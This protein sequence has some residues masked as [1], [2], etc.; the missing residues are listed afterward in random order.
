MHR[1]HQLDCIA[2]TT[3]VQD[4][5]FILSTSM[6]LS[7]SI[8][9]FK[10]H[11][12]LLGCFL[13]SNFH[14]CQIS[15]PSLNPINPLQMSKSPHNIS[16][17]QVTDHK[18]LIYFIKLLNMTNLLHPNSTN[19]S[20]IN[21]SQQNKLADI[22]NAFKYYPESQIKVQM[23]SHIH[24]IIPY[25]KITSLIFFGVHWTN[26]NQQIEQVSTK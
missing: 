25:A 3:G 26:D 4:I 11:Q 13:K 10:V 16:T 20:N 7:L 23:T 22:N 21:N 15:G 5:T 24:S 6:P 14:F 1:K 9:S 19:D 18:T 8:S 17:N 12:S 2:P